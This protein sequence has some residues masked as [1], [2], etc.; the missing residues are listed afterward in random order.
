MAPGGGVTRAQLLS[1]DCRRC[2]SPGRA[3]GTLG[4]F[5]HRLRRSRVHLGMLVKEE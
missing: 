1:N 4:H 2:P 5:R 3:E